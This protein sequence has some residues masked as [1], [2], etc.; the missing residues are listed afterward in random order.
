MLS[1]LYV[2]QYNEL[3][4]D[5]AATDYDDGHVST[6]ISEVMGLHA[7]GGD[8][9]DPG[10]EL[11]VKGWSSTSGTVPPGVPVLDMYG[12][13]R[14]EVAFVLQHVAGRRRTTTL[15]FDLEIGMLAEEVRVATDCDDLEHRAHDGCNAKFARQTIDKYVMR[16]RLYGA[17]EAAMA[18]Y[19]QIALTPVPD[20]AEG[21]AWLRRGKSVHLPGFDSMRGVY[22]VLLMED[23]YGISASVT[24]TWKWWRSAGLT[25]AVT[26]APYNA[27]SLWGRYLVEA[28]FYHRD[29]DVYRLGSF[30]FASAPA[31]AYYAYA[32]LLTGG[33]VYCAVPPRY[34]LT[35]APWDEDHDYQI[36]VTVKDLAMTG[37]NITTVAGSSMLRLQHVP[38]PCSATFVLGRMPTGGA[39]SALSSAFD[40]TIQRADDA[41]VVP[42][43][44]KAWCFGMA[45]RWLGYNTVMRYGGV[46]RLAN[47]ASNASS[48]AVRP[49]HVAGPDIKTVEI[50]SVFERQRVWSIMPSMGNDT[51]TWHVDVDVTDTYS[52]Q[53]I[54][55]R[56]M[57]VTGTFATKK[58]ADASIVVPSLEATT[59]TPIILRSHRPQDP[60][61]A[62]FQVVFGHTEHH[63]PAK[64]VASGPGELI[65][66]DTT[67]LPVGV[68]AA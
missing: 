65:Q 64:T 32:S 41:W 55:T 68:S 20:T 53:G 54:N 36:P 7:A 52:L 57:G 34:G 9:R 38:P 14:A 51:T 8:W 18:I 27:L 4:A 17:F 5:T 21:L 67:D 3:R 48:V 31:T 43:V 22:P 60:L 58:G 63:P 1:S 25:T 16:N 15:A 11:N 61:E 12:M 26:A 29:A 56:L 50:I 66:E 44:D 47:W 46:E 49:F 33:D 37:Y 35:Y 10:D 30:E 39:F 19:H 62:G 23:A 2:L 6:K 45:T 40:I 13:R 24:H 28:G 42:S 59:F